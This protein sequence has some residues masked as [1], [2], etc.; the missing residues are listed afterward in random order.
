MRHYLS[1]LFAPKSVALVG[2]SDRVGSLG[3]TVFENLL[4]GQFAGDIYAVN[5][6]H[7]SVF[8]R[9]AYAS[10]AAIGKPIDLAII[11]TPPAPIA[12]IRSRRCC[13]RVNKW[14]PS[15]VGSTRTCAVSL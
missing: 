5:P 14:P 8:G 9:R 1:P 7:R 12:G 6:N 11:A 10:L 2:A 3:R 15:C 13:A 4:S